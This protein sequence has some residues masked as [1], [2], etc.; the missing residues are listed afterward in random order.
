MAE[1]ASLGLEVY[2]FWTRDK[3]PDRDRAIHASRYKGLRISE[4]SA[5]DLPLVDMLE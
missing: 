1:Q 2:S 4:S 5:S 3:A